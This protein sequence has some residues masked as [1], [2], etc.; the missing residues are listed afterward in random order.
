MGQKRLRFA[1]FTLIELL[2]VIAVICVLVSLALPALSRAKGLAR[3]TVCVNNLRQLGQ[4]MGLYCAD[5]GRFPSILEWLYAW[6]SNQVG[7]VGGKL[8]PYLRSRAVY[9]CPLDAVDTGLHSSPGGLPP[10]H[11]Y[12]M[13]CMICHAH[14]I[15]AC[16][17]PART[18]LFTEQVSPAPTLSGGLAE[19]VPADAPPGSAPSPVDFRHSQRGHLLM[20]DSHLETMDQRQYRAA[21][22]AREFWYPNERTDRLGNP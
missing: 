15:T 4:G 16:T 18:I 1:A 11:S 13:N 5:A 3:T 9:L 8:Y 2:V 21:L 19:P 7:L 14:D 22:Y 12:M 6:P 10:D 17:S 20:V